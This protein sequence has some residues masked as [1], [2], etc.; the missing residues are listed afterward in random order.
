MLHERLR[1]AQKVAVGVGTVAVVVIA[2]GYGQVPWVALSLAITFALYGL[3]KKKV[4]GLVSPLVGL[5]IET[6]LLTP[7][8]LVFLVWLQ[9]SGSGHYVSQGPGLTLGLTLAGV[10]TAFPL[11]LFAAASSRIPLSMMGLIQYLTPVIQFSIGVWVNHEVMPAPRWIGFGLVWV[12]LVVLT[13][14]SLR[15]ARSRDLVIEPEIMD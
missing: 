10:V 3:V 7:V 14:D 8:A 13:I 11:L 4:G 1:T 5:T 9:A 2:I 15:A 12:A 6:A